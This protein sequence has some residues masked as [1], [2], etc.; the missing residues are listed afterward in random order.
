MNKGHREELAYDILRKLYLD[1]KRSSR[2]IAKKLGCSEHKVN[3]WLLK[4]TIT[5]RSIS[6][7][8]YAARN[9]NGDPF[10]IKE[11]K[12]IE[13]A[14]LFGFGMGLYWG[15]GNKKNKNSVRLGNTDPKLIQK[16]IDFLIRI[17]GVKP[18]K[19][20][21]GLQIFGDMPKR[22]ALE[23][24]LATLR[25]FGIHKDQF[26]KVTVT[27]HRGVGNYREKTMHGVLTVY[28]GNSKLKRAI[29]SLLPE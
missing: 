22:S 2:E 18:S 10:H 17:C 12:T 6:E 24:W 29:D 11:I 25:R 21:F 13:D 27:L 5:K 9:P 14:K 20:H 23:F 19:M 15:E 16:F 26:F 3:Y 7:A 28:V 1:E 8:V 4:H